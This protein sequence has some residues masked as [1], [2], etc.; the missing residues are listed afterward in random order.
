M[1]RI[2]ATDTIS[3]KVAR[4]GT[5]FQEFALNGNRTVQDLLTMANINPKASE[6]IRINGEEAELDD[7]LEDGDMVTLV[8]DIEGGSR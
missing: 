1:T 2:H 4:V 8:K 7:E 6:S 5:Q 3:A